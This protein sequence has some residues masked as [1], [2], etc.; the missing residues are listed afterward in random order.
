MSK[1][2]IL[3]SGAWGTALAIHAARMAHSVTMWAFEQEVANEIQQ[4]HTNSTYLPAFVLPSSIQATVDL[5]EAVVSAEVVILVC[6]SKYLRDLCSQLAQCLPSQAIVLVATKGIEPSSLKFGSGILDDTLPHVGYERRAVLSGPSFA[7]E[8]AHGRPTDVVV[9]SKAMIA[10]KKIQPLLHGARFRVY[11]SADPIG[12]EVG[13]A[14]KNVIA[15]AMGAC[16][17]LQLG[18]NARAALMTRG[19]AEMTRLGV[20][21]G[22]DPLTFLGLAGVGDLILTCTGE[23]SRNRTLGWNIA[24]GVD[25]HSFLESRRSVAEGFLTSRAAYELAQLHKIDMPIT[26]QVYHVLHQGRPL[27][28]AVQQLIERNFKEELQGIR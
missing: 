2:A 15:I 4:Q 28:E 17:R 7:K 16:D 11:A 20:P 21:L 22:A 18:H 14:L 27:H 5:A 13:G 3:G 9:A 1:V 19:L 24:E 10:A 26:E 23:L 8:V 25:P 6:P 12:V